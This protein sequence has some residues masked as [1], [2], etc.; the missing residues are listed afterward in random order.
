[1]V[2]HQRTSESGGAK[3]GI[4]KEIQRAR[5]GERT[6]KGQK[7]TACQITLGGEGRRKERS[8]SEGKGRELKN[9]EAKVGARRTSLGK[10]RRGAF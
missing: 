9:L 6:I 10:G 4:S 5:G 2:S 1:M 8:K 3:A 7:E